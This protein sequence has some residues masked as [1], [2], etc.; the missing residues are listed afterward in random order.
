MNIHGQ[1]SSSENEVIVKSNALDSHQLKTDSS[2]PWKVGCTR[3]SK[4]EM[5]STSW[6]QEM[7][8]RHVL[9]YN[10]ERYTDPCLLGKKVCPLVRNQAWTTNI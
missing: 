7:R 4:E 3:E 2:Y 8:Y 10:F 5:N 6:M 1:H 9:K